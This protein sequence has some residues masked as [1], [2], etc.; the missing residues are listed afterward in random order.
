VKGCGS[1]SASL[2]IS[3]AASVREG[4]ETGRGG[5]C[6]KKLEQLSGLIPDDNQKNVRRF[7]GASR[8]LG[9]SSLSVGI[10]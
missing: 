3:R 6:V 1:F 7:G 5:A 2:A 8:L 4:E 9:S 10:V